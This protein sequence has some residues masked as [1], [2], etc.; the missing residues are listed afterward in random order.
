MLYTLKGAVFINNE[1]THFESKSQRT[2]INETNMTKYLSITKEHIL[3]ANHNCYA[4]IS[5]S[6]SVFINNERTHFE[7]KSQP[8]NCAKNNLV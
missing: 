5:N 2:Q 8:V 7:S 6:H 3:K 1:R 4:E